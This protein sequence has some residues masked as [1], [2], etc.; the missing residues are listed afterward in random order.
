M[1][2]SGKAEVGKVGD[3]WGEM[4]EGEGGD[5]NWLGLPGVGGREG[6]IRHFK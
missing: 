4:V 2:W 3:Q 1:H 6:G 5:V